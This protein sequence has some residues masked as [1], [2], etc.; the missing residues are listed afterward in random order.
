VSELPAVPIPL[1]E[2]LPTPPAA[3]YPT[4]PAGIAEA[5][6]I[7]QVKFFSAPRKLLIVTVPEVEILAFAE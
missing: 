6:D 1:R 5:A 4:N 7:E 3:E 2:T